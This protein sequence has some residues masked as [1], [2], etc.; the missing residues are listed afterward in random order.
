MEK[1]YKEVRQLR[2][3]S[4]DGYKTEKFCHYVWHNINTK[5]L[6]KP[7]KFKLKTGPEFD[8]WIDSLEEEYDPKLI[9][10]ILND[11]H[12]WLLTFET[13]RKL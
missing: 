12:F 10:A 5:K 6:K 11:D 1:W 2:D 7:E 3:K 9:K 4:E 13:A 8:S